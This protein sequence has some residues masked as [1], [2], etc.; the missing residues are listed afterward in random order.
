MNDRSEH[1]ALPS[2]F[3]SQPAK[4]GSPT[5]LMRNAA[6]MKAIPPVVCP[7]MSKRTAARKTIPDTMP[8]ILSDTASMNENIADAKV[9]A[10]ANGTARSFNMSLNIVI[11][12]PFK[13]CN[14]LR[15]TL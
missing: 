10:N 2:L 6:T 15:F 9:K 11:T 1:P 3:T 14:F 13:P 4:A 8:K 12:N 5:G 7:V